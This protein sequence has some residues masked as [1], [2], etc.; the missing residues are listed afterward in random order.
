M[1][2]NA[3]LSA[4]RVGFGRLIFVPSFNMK[5]GHPVLFDAKIR[6]EFLQ[7]ND[8]APARA[9]VNR[10]A[11]RVAYVET[12]DDHLLMDMDTPEDYARCLARYRERKS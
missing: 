2:I 4:R 12:P 5:R 8:D 3:L 7:L 9:V 11:D 10:N 1:D 6:E